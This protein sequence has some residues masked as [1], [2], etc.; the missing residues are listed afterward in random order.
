MKVNCKGLRGTAANRPMRLNPTGIGP[1]AS[2]LTLLLGG[3]EW[4]A[5][6]SSIRAK[7]NAPKSPSEREKKQNEPLTGP[8]G[9]LESLATGRGRPAV[10]WGV[11]AHVAAGKLTQRL[12]LHIS[13]TCFTQLQPK[14][15]K[16][17]MK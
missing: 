6:L 8:Q 5:G 10:A 11:V 3:G 4:L 17:E 16:N 7:P 15:S 9:L 14:R 13:Y 2:H 12:R 1:R